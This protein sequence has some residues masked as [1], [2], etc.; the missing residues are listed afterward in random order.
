MPRLFFFLQKE[1][2]Q[3][4]RNKAILRLSIVMPMMQ[5]LL[6]P[7]AADYEV[8]HINLAVVDQDRTPYSRQ[9][10]E[11][12]TASGYFQ[13]VAHETAYPT[14]LER[15]HAGSCDLV[16]TIP[17]GFERDLVRDA[18]AQ[19]HLAADA[20]TGIKANLG[21]AYAQRIVSNFSDVL[22]RDGLVPPRRNEMPVVEIVQANWY[23]P[24]YNYKLFM[25]PGILAI[26]VTMVGVTMSSLNLVAEKEMGTIEQ[27]NVTPLRKWEFVL[28]KLL[29]FW[30]LGLVSL[31]VGLT[32]AYVVYGLV[33][34]GSYFTILS[35]AALYLFGVLG[36]GL[37]MSTFSDTQQQVTLFSFFVTM[38]FVL[39]SGLYT[40]IESM[41]EW[42]QWLARL[43]PP[44]YIVRCI[45]SVFVKGSGFWDLRYEILWIFGF[46]V[47]FNALAIWNYRKKGG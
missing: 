8:K 3:M 35:I 23:N 13:L 19:L 22:R 25:V 30:V 36:I 18:H 38:F 46:A 11:A 42:A 2:R 34:L 45:R 15:V 32:V 9:L 37:L 24:H 29:P 10:T 6:I 21:A 40:S 41:P 39:M 1:F 16:L 12:M 28:G 17:R 20:V 7:M 31:T 26:L 43:N 47:F 44:T 27:L 14:A 5:L 33:P 4:F